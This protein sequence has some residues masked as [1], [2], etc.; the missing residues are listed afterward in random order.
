MNLHGDGPKHRFV[1]LTRSQARPVAAILLL[2]LS[3]APGFRVSGAEDE[4]AKT[5]SEASAKRLKIMQSAIDDFTVVS[6][7]IASPVS[8][9]FGS[10]PLLRYSDETRGRDALTNGVLDAGVWRLGEQG[11][12]TAIVTIEIYRYREKGALL[13]YEFVSLAPSPFEMKSVRGPQW[14]APNSELKMNR[15]EDAPAPADSPRARLTQMRQL[16]RRF[17]AHEE[18]GKDKFECR[19]LSQPID[20]YDDQNAGIQDVALFVFAN[21]TNPEIGLL[22]ECSAERWSYGMFRLGSAALF[23]RFDDKLVF[24]MPRITQYP[25]AAPYT[26]TRHPIPLPE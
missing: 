19:L 2:A 5:A 13:T 23:A 8:L 20:R 12:P 10:Q 14:I 17:T 9:K 21:G 22:L 15:L 26:A 6:K 25:S 7:A 3:A 24:E 4:A 11:R 18:L 1:T 16:S